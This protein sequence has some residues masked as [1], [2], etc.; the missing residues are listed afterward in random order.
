ME[1]L[2]NEYIKELNSSKLTDDAIQTVFSK[3]DK[4]SIY[5]DSNDLENYLISTKGEYGGIGIS[6][7]LNKSIL[8]IMY[9]YPGSPAQKFGILP[10]DIILKINHH[11]TLGLSIDACSNLAKGK[12]DE[13]LYLTIIRKSE[14]RPLLFEIKRKKIKTDPLKSKKFTGNILYVKIPIFNE[15]SSTELK[16]ILKKNTHLQGIILDLRSNP[17]GILNQAV[18]IVDMFI[19]K[20]LIVSQKGRKKRH[21]K[22]FIAHKRNTD[23][24][25]QLAI[26][27]D[28]ASA[29]ASEIVAGALK[30]HK[31]ATIIGEKSFGKG[32][33]QALFSLD[34]TS[35]I[36]LT[37][38][39]YYLPNGKCI[40]NIGISPHVR[41]KSHNLI[42]KNRYIVSEKKL[43][44]IVKKLENG[45]LKLKTVKKMKYKESTPDKIKMDKVLK[46]ALQILVD[47]GPKN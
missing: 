43:K 9:T 21:T 35:A 45:S 32:S 24:Q 29:S 38:A 7:Y 46:K 42:S 8:T 3:L 27:I 26:L 15:S 12:V 1:I 23:T 28:S 39:K 4:H 47:N 5:L 30:V 17:G 10:G 25:T 34:K 18:S 44:R 31:R 19:D 22:Q 13:I 14:K 33:V 16:K 11:P 41:I 37:I 2:D 20:G 36:K 40:A 6:M